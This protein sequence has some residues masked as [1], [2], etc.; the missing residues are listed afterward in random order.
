MDLNKQRP[1]FY[2]HR[3][4]GDPSDPQPLRRREDVAGGAFSRESE[5][6]LFGRGD[7]RTPAVR[8]LRD[9]RPGNAGAVTGKRSGD[10]AVRDKSARPEDK[11]RVAEQWRKSSG[12]P[13]LRKLAASAPPPPPMARR[14]TGPAAPQASGCGLIALVLVLAGALT[15]AATQW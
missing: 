13:K 12:P 8:S 6:K 14:A 3:P 15:R 2:Q 1:S 4:K 7:P 5:E 10:D 11:Q 9:G